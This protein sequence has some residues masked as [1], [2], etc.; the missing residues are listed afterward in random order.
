M[1]TFAILNFYFIIVIFLKTEIISSWGSNNSSI[2]TYNWELKGQ[3]YQG[4]QNIES[5]I[6]TK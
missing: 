3:I 6:L 2:D 5:P 4:G 1:M